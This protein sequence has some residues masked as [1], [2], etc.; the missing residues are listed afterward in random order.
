MNC[1]YI[2]TMICMPSCPHLLASCVLV[3]SR[4]ECLRS[5]PELQLLSHSC[6]SNL[7]CKSPVPSILTSTSDRG[8]SPQCSPCLEGPLYPET[9][10]D[11]SHSRARSLPVSPASSHHCP[12]FEVDAPWTQWSA[13]SP[14]TRALP[15]PQPLHSCYP[16][17]EAPPALLSCPPFRSELQSS[18]FWEACADLPGTLYFI[19]CMRHPPAAVSKF[20]RWTTYSVSPPSSLGTLSC[21]QEGRDSRVHQT[22][23]WKHCF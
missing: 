5:H 18:S 20:L 16:A 23:V 9:A 6:S 11:R 7:P 1:V 22:H 13:G 15:I 21:S 17:R 14:A 4:N 10:G 8:I 12:T 2:Q 19:P 3:I